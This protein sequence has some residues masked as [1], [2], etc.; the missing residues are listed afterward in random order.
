MFGLG[1]SSP[2]QGTLVMAVLS[3]SGPLNQSLLGMF[4]ELCGP[5]PVEISTRVVGPNPP[6]EDPFGA[7]WHQN[8]VIEVENPG[9]LALFGFREFLSKE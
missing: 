5:P 4:F 6:W 1:E 8:T 9:M 2:P 7:N 3:L